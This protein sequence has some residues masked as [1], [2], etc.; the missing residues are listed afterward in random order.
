MCAP[1]L[2]GEFAALTSVDAFPGNLPLQASSF[3]GRDR[4]IDRTVAALSD[5]RVVT[6][7]GVGGVGQDPFGVAGRGGG[8]A[9]VPRRRLVD[10]TGGECVIPTMWSMRSRRCS[11]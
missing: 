3:I 4:E 1:G 5:A 2:L 6:L 11:G 7:T 9:P 8:V 10:R